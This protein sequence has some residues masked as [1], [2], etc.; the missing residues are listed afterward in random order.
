MITNVEIPQVFNAAS[1]L[2]DPNLEAGRGDKVAI[3]YLEQQVTYAKMA[4]MVNRTGNALKTLGVEMENR[5]LL[6][7]LDCPEFIYS[8]LGAIKMGA[9]PIPVNTLLRPADYEYIFND[10]RARVLVVTDELLPQVEQIKEKLKYLKEIIVV[11]AEKAGCHAFNYLVAKAAPVLATAE[12]SKDDAAFWLYSSG[13]TGA[14][15]GAVH[16]HHD[17][18]YAADLYARNIL[19]VGPDDIH[20]SVAKLFFA[21]GLGNG[22]YFAFR[23]GGATVLYPGRPL[24]EDLFK[25]VQKYRPTLF[26]GVPTAFNN[27]LQIKDAEKIY[28]FSSVRLCTSA[29]EALPATVYHQWLQRFNVEILDGIGSTEM[30]HIYISNRVGQVRPGSSGF[31]VPG[32]EVK[33]VDE[34]G[35]EAPR[36]EIGTLYAKGDSAAAY[37]WN[38]HDKTKQTMLGE[39]LNTGDK[40]YQDEDGYWWPVGRSDDML[41][42]GGIWVSP[43]EV[44]NALV[45]HRAVL[46]AA[47]VGAPDQDGLIK[48]LAYVVLKEGFQPADSLGQELQQFVK[49]KIAP[50]KYP[51]WI[52]FVDEL[53]KTATG[54]IQRYRLRMEDNNK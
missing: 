14:P 16:L 43:V 33:A 52:K 6:L 20:F 13:S 37:Y 3:Y 26:F 44:E 36:G 10:S 50:Y 48:P 45:E 15:K 28:D 32:Y 31:A 18:L 4:E 27:M 12:T 23:V 40:Y 29:G 47:V 24:A 2:I 25:V 9:V 8:F 21:Y 46:E 39:W 19:N 22:S 38:R 49:S 11:G 42:A 53:P 54:K 51:R 30:L 35:Q 1:A 7:M 41:K 17:M 5:V 34:D